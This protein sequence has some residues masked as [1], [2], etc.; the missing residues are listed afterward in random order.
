M[1]SLVGMDKE[2]ILDKKKT[3]LIDARVKIR[4]KFELARIRRETQRD[5]QAAHDLM[6]GVWFGHGL[7]SATIHPIAI[8][9]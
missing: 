1:P 2:V 7:E 8:P 3:D 6:E 4:H 9:E 5:E